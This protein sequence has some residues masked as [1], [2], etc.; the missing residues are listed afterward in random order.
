MDTGAEA[1]PPIGNYDPR[2]H[3]HSEEERGSTAYYKL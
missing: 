2:I 3:G 1:Y